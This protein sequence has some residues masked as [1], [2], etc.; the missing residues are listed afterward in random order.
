MTSW[1]VTQDARFDA[2]IAVAPHTNQVSEHLL[3]NIPHFVALFL[4]D[5][6]DKPDS[7]Y[8]HRSPIMHAHKAQ[9]PTLNICGA[10]DR[11]TPPEEALQ[12]HNALLENG[13]ISVLVTYPQEG[14]GIRGF[15]AAIDFAARVVL[16]FEQH[17]EVAGDLL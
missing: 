14:H 16:W 4:N 2:A 15:P 6:Y 17:I 13:V 5:K 9:T 1:L 11:C 10:L 7:Q 12:F 3:S 8:F